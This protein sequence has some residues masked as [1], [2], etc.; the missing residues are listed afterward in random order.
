MTDGTDGRWSCRS[1]QHGKVCD[2]T[3]PDTAA[4]PTR[5]SPASVPASSSTFLAA[6]RSRSPPR[7]SARSTG[8]IP[9]AGA[10]GARAACI[11]GVVRP[12]RHLHA[13]K[14]H[15][16]DVRHLPTHGYACCVKPNGA[17]PRAW[18]H[19]R[20]AATAADMHADL[21]Q[22]HCTP[23]TRQLHSAPDDLGDRHQNPL[24]VLREGVLLRRPRLPCL[25]HA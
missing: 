21:V 8:S 5:S 16:D 18:I 23:C 11:E 6:S 9:K 12:C 2:R 20:L 15:T 1:Q 17:G 13:S 25:R 7:R 14:H 10:S 24:H 22:S 3:V 19:W 4:T